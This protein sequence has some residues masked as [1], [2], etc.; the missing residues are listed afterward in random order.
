M[1]SDKKVESSEFA[2]FMDAILKVTFDK[3][4]Q[5][6]NGKIDASEVGVGCIWLRS[7]VC[8]IQIAT[9]VLIMIDGVDFNKLTAE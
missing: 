3:I 8:C 1:N 9:L 7:S 2:K 5:N 4:D 6:K